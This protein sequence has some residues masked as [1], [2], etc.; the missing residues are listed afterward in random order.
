MWLLYGQIRHQLK[1][2]R[3]HYCRDN[4]PDL[5]YQ[6]HHGYKVCLVVESDSN[7]SLEY[8]R[9]LGGMRLRSD[10]RLEA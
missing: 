8:P 3:R 4:T 7:P 1:P 9:N 5:R 6:L 10:L 2:R